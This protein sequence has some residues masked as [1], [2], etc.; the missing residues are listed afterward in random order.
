ML[1]ASKSLMQA[2]VRHF[3]EDWPSWSDEEWFT[4][5][6]REDVSLMGLGRGVWDTFVI[7]VRDWDTAWDEL[8]EAHGDDSKVQKLDGVTKFLRDLID[9]RPT[10]EF[11]QEVGEAIDNS[12]RETHKAE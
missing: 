3:S 6:G 12:Y 4:D 8:I 7:D 5:L 1:N 9:G 2:I 11:M 10:R